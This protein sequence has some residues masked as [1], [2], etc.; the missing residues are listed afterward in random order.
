MLP[1][2]IWRGRA[3]ERTQRRSLM[4]GGACEARSAPSSTMSLRWSARLSFLT[5]FAASEVSGIC[6]HTSR[7]SGSPCLTWYT[8]WL[9]LVLSSPPIAAPA[10]RLRDASWTSHDKEATWGPTS[11]QV[12]SLN[13]KFASEVKSSQ[14]DLT[15]LDILQATFRSF[16]VAR[17]P[18]RPTVLARPC[19]PSPYLPGPPTRMTTSLAHS[20]MGSGVYWGFGVARVSN[21]EWLSTS[22]TQ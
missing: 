5:S 18:C 19:R 15:L 17:T 14:V 1:G 10:G 3:R 22:A 13:R 4:H 20:F 8:G 9:M 2:C 11:F 16:R 6:F 21:H 7:K 12:S